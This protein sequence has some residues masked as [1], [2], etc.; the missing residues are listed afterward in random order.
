MVE[1]EFVS[2]RA[3]EGG[4]MS[5]EDSSLRATKNSWLISSLKKKES[6]H[7]PSFTLLI[8]TAYIVLTKKIL[9][10]CSQTQTS[11]TLQQLLV[12]RSRQSSQPAAHCFLCSH[13]VAAGLW[14]GG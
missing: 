11:L 2:E 6:C 10:V 8:Y 13:D 7:S 12:Q 3:C 5:L 1:C 14:V 4:T 9:S